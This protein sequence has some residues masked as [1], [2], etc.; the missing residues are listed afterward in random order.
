ML[1][2]RCF[3]KRLILRGFELVP[4][5]ICLDLMAEMMKRT[6]DCLPG[7]YAGDYGG[8]TGGFQRQM[9]DEVEIRELLIFY[10]VGHRCCWGSRPARTWKFYKLRTAM[11]MSELWTLSLMKEKS[12]CRERRSCLSYLAIQ[13][14]NLDSTTKNQMTLCPSCH[15]RGLI[16]RRDGSD[17]TCAKCNGKRKIPSV[18][19]GSCGLVRC[20]TCKGSGSLLSLENTR[21]PVP[22]TAGVICERHEISVVRVTMTHRNRAFRLYAVG[23][24]REVYLKEYYPSMFCR[25]MRLVSGGLVSPRPLR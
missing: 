7:A 17:S 9:L 2:I 10:H 1:I 21:A 19:C 18:T 20:E 23:N 14:K 11:S 13:I 4:E 25:G 15:G 3:S 24:S 6:Y 5:D 16:A 12:L 22:A 8:A